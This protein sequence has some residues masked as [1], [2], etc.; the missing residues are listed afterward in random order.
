MGERQNVTLAKDDST[1]KPKTILRFR[2]LKHSKNL[3]A[4]SLAATSSK[5][6]YGHALDEFIGWCCS[7][8]R[9]EFSCWPRG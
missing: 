5:Q 7:E 2:D 9:L 1:K 3:V 8:P 6:S 4:N